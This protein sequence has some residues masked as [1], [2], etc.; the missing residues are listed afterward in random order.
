MGQAQNLRN[1]HMRIGFFAM[2][3][4]LALSW[5]SLAHAQPRSGHTDWLP[6]SFDWEVRGNTGLALR[7]VL[8]NGEL[9]LHKASMPVIRVKYEKEWPIWHPYAWWPFRKFDFTRRGGKCGP[10]QDR[11]SW[12]R[13]KKRPE[14]GGRKVCIDSY[15]SNGVQWLEIG[16]FG[17]IGEYDLYQAWYLSQDGQLNVSVQSGGLSCHT[18]HD[19]HAYWRFDFAVKDKAN[20]Q[21]FVH[22]PAAPDSGW[23]AGWTKYTQE[24]DTVKDAQGDR[25]WFVR[26]HTTGHGVWITPGI[27]DG[28]ADFFSDRDAS[29]R[30]FKAAEDEP[31][32]FGARRE[33]EY[34]EEEDIQET[35]IVFWYVAHLPHKLSAGAFPTDAFVGPTLQVH[36]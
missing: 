25:R 11:L 20:D 7:N 8:Y 29:P 27:H 34:N 30:L 24:L 16:A 35:D 2:T 10:F 23:G 14:C 22:D 3:V 13:F 1:V 26:D 36:R 5:S 15:F 4:V 17:E 28:E 6:W 31:W 18:D 12:G 32:I 33:L 9:V 19:H 21:V